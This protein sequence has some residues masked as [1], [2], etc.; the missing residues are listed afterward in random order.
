M[1]PPLKIELAPLLAG[2]VDSQG[3]EVRIPFATF[4]GQTGEKALTLDLEEDG[5]VIVV[6][7]IDVEDIPDDAE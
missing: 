2:I 4:V 3:G 1:A 5:A 7:L 6:R